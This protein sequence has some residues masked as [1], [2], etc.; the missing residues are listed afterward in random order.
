M[1]Q[2]VTVSLNKLIF[3]DDQLIICG[4]VFPHEVIGF[5][6]GNKYFF[7]GIGGPEIIN[8]THWLV[9]VITSYKVIGV[10]TVKAPSKRS[11]LNEIRTQHQA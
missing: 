5:S 6:E 7:P 4:P 8:F 9:A 11:G 3:D 1:A 10:S 2:D